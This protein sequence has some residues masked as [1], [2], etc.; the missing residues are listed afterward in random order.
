MNDTISK[1][2]EIYQHM[3]IW[4]VNH[5]RNSL[6]QPWYIRLR[7]RSSVILANLLHYIPV[8]IFGETVGLHDVRFFDVGVSYFITQY[9]TRSE[10]IFLIMAD[11]LL[12]LYELVNQES[13][14]AIHWT[15]PD[16][17]KEL[18]LEFRLNNQRTLPNGEELAE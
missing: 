5:L 8:R 18:V 2:S 6:E 14:L 9:P 16:D 17:V 12:E 7:D 1:R 10:H 4:G 11:L 13:H 15:F 3:L